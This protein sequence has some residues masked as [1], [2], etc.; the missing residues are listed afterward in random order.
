LILGLYKAKSGFFSEIYKMKFARVP[1]EIMH[2]INAGNLSDILSEYRFGVLFNKAEKGWN[3]EVIAAFS[4]EKRS[5][6]FDL[7]FKIRNGEGSKFMFGH[8][9]YNFKK[10][11]EQ[12]YCRFDNVDGFPDSAFLSPQIL[13]RKK[14]E[15]N[16]EIGYNT[17]EQFELF[18]KR[19]KNLKSD[20][21][22][23]SQIR[24]NAHLS[25]KAYIEK[26]IE[27][28][29]HI[30]RGD[31]YEVN[32]CQGFSAQTRVFNPAKAYLKLIELTDAPFGALY[33]HEDS[34]LICGSPERYVSR[35]GDTVISQ[36][37]K[38]TR[39]RSEEQFADEQLK[40]ELKND[41]KER[42]ENVMIV[43][44]VRNDLSR[45]AMP[46]S[47]EVSE[48]FGIH[49]F[50]TVHQMISTVRCTVS[51]E[52]SNAEILLKTFP[53]GSMTGAPKR[54]AVELAEQ[55]ETQA[56]GIY[57]GTVGVISPE[58]DFDF[59]VVIRSITWNSKTGYLSVMAG[60][61]ITAQSDP[62]KEYEECMLK[63]DAM[64]KVIEN[65]F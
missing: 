6:D 11:T 22:H 41:P 58:G 52:I 64:K 65:G 24:L 10:N 3:T 54:R 60:S 46:G 5:S 35:T 15:N 4:N 16:F 33:K 19:I 42:S 13:I 27:L 63:L 8:I 30:Q 49:T 59:N 26:T 50:K 17:D 37:I 21:S 23:H 7:T 61:A 55:H 1:I 57:S 53:M 28:L 12:V 25:K 18:T 14:E 20:N 56:R 45:F 40:E 2:L 39:K 62:E 47:V 32:F 38:G 31:I 36:P 44:L 51:S 43:D 9:G 34:W 48:L 29:R